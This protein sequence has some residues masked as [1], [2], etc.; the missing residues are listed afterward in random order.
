MLGWYEPV[1][2]EL[3][4]VLN[5]PSKTVYGRMT[6]K[7]QDYADQLN[8]RVCNTMIKKDIENLLRRL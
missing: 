4:E 7:E 8:R 3:H 6:E 1:A 5:P 2:L